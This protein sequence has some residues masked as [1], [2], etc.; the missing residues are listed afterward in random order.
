[1]LL[2]N[3]KKTD[4]VKPHERAQ[5]IVEDRIVVIKCNPFSVCN[6]FT[7]ILE[8]YEVNNVLESSLVR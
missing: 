1:M 7:G 3:Y 4:S 5:Y 8:K 6:R 2:K